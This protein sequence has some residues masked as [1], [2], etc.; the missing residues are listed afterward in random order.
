MFAINIAIWS[1]SCIICNNNILQKGAFT[2]KE[3]DLYQPIKQLLTSQGFT[4]KGEV[5]KCDIAAIREDELWIVEIK[6]HLS[7]KLLY[8]AMSRLAI[9]PFVYIAI[10]RPKRLDAGFRSAK[11]VLKKLELGL[12]TVAM[13]SSTPYAEIALFPNMCHKKTTKKAAAIRKEI[14]GRTDDTPGGS[15]GVTITSAY[16]ERAIKIACILFKL[17][18]DESMSTKELKEIHGC[19]PDTTSI[20]YN[21]YYGWFINISRGRYALSKTGKKFLCENADNRIVAY[22]IQ[23]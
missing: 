2:I 5:K 22:Y 13:D 10:P 16:R 19:E 18:E 12:I 21:N 20:L 23:S 4:V 17:K 8:Q 6:R 7:M 15:T 1:L 11:K 3:S 9:T 14:E